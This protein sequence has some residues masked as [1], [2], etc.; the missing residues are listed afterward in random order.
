M[1]IGGFGLQ[2]VVVLSAWANVCGKPGVARPSRANSALV[3][4]TCGQGMRMKTSSQNTWQREVLE[5]YL[6]LSHYTASPRKN[7]QRPGHHHRLAE[8]SFR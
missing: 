3:E 1:V 2:H 5:S 4:G 7:L 6:G 8:E